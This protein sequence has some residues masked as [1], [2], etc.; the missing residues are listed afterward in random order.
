MPDDPAHERRTRAQ[1][2]RLKVARA[3]FDEL[4]PASRAA[5]IRLAADL[6]LDTVGASTFGRHDDAATGKARIPVHIARI[7][8]GR[9]LAGFS[10]GTL[11]I[12]EHGKVMM[13]ELA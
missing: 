12:T 2:D 1:V 6:Q 10:A 5:L 13:R 11:W 3:T 7:L 9:K 8:L 4:K